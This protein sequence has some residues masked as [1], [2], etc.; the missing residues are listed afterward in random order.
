MAKK[1][2]A[3]ISLFNARERYFQIRK[4]LRSYQSLMN[5]IKDNQHP[6]VL[7]LATHLANLNMVHAQSASIFESGDPNKI[8]SKYLTMLKNFEMLVNEFEAVLLEAHAELTNV[9]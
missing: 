3:P 4:K 8:T 6:G 7:D 2:D 5:D 9:K 1:E